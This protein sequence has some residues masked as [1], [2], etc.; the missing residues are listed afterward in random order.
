MRYPLY[1]TVTKQKII[2]HIRA[3]TFFPSTYMLHSTAAY[4]NAFIT[5]CSCTL[6]IAI[7][8][9]QALYNTNIANAAI[10]KEPY[11][12]PEKRNKVITVQQ[13]QPRRKYQIPNRGLRNPSPPTT[14][15]V[16]LATP[17]RTN[18]RLLHARTALLLSYYQIDG[19]RVYIRAQKNV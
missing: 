18:D 9:H 15:P 8:H 5:I 14:T 10:T 7:T 13:A 17:S 1:Y 3:L 12:L 16:P 2:R 6:I 19:S 4:I 11:I